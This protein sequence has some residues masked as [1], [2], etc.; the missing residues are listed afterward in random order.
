MI[1]FCLMGLVSVSKQIGRYTS[2]HVRVF[3]SRDE[4]LDYCADYKNVIR[5]IIYS[6]TYKNRIFKW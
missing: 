3:S 2:R 5:L 4:F 6:K 1:H